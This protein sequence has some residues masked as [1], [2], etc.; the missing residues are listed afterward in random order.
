[1]DN[2]LV[3]CMLCGGK[4]SITKV[5][6]LDG[7]VHYDDWIVKCDVCGSHFDLAADGYY[8]REYF[9]EEAAIGYWNKLHGGEFVDK[10]R[11]QDDG[12]TV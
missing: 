8:G 4:A 6:K 1:M 9:T 10:K 7:Y 2:R 5:E 11:Q 12:R 3:P